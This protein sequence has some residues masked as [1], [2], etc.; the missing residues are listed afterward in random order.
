[1]PIRL[2]VIFLAV[3]ALP[4][5]GRAGSDGL[6]LLGEHDFQAGGYSLVGL[7]WNRPRHPL[8]KELGEFYVDEPAVLAEMQAEWRAGEPAPFYACGYHYTILLVRA[9][10]VLDSLAINL[11]TECGTVVTDTGSFRFDTALLTRHADRYRK[12]VA[13]HSEFPTLAE[14][15]AYLAEIDGDPRLLLKPKP[16]WRN[17]DGEFRFMLPCPGHDFDDGKVAACISRL[18]A[19]IEAKYPDESFDLMEAGGR[20]DFV[21]IEMKCSKA[22]HDRF[23]L[24]DDYWEWRDYEPALTL[25][26]KQPE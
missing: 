4:L 20:T 3:M 17:Y 8:Q 13:E 21:M 15:H 23:D 5:P 2:F 14:A 11:E 9:G 24:Y 19:E 18:S 25:Y 26:W 10:E 16:Q 1:M 7:F 22:L 12:P 6:P